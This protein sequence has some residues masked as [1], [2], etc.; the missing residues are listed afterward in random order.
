MYSSDNSN[1]NNDNDNNGKST[2]LI[3]VTIYCK[4]W[5]HDNYINSTLIQ[6]FMTTRFQK[7]YLHF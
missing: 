6:V 2:I 4:V 3:E 7:H 1:G 5:I